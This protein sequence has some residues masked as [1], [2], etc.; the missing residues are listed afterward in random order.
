MPLKEAIEC[1]HKV[2]EQN[3]LSLE[4]KDKS[5]TMVSLDAKFGNII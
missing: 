1:Y 2:N 3:N 4:N 5:Q